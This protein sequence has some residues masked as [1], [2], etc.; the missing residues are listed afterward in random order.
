MKSFALN[1]LLFITTA[2]SA[3]TYTTTTTGGTWT[4]AGTSG[5]GDDLVINH[6]WSAYNSPLGYNYTNLSTGGSITVNSGGSFNIWG[7]LV[8]QNSSSI[9]INSG[10]TLEADGL[11]VQTS[12]TLDV[13]SGGTLLVTGSISLV[14]TAGAITFDGAITANGATNNASTVTGS[15][16]WTYTGS[17]ANSGTVNGETGDLGASPIDLSA[18]PVELTKFSVID[19]GDFNQVIWQTSSEVNNDYFEVQ[20]SYDGGNFSMIEVVQGA[21]N[22]IEIID[23][24]YFD[25]SKSSGDAYYR[26]KQVDF[27]GD[28]EYSNIVLVGDESQGIKIVEDIMAEDVKVIANGRG[29][30]IIQIFDLGGR[31]IFKSSF[32]TEKGGIYTF[33]VDKKGL[34]FAVVSG[35]NSDISKKI[36]FK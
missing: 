20:K 9:T 6:D 7:S 36:V 30:Y 8:A 11:T 25:Y 17:W 15:G 31:L 33:P 35:R 32:Q 19:N 13:N 23:Y 2:V 12:A 3:A 24:N 22:S 16:T 14:S 27:N 5:S 18:L 26:L 1:A 28:F 34:F 29:D 4:P 10:G 21:G